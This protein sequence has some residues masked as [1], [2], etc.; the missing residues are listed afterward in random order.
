MKGHSIRML[1][2]A[3]VLATVVL[4]ACGSGAATPKE[5]SVEASDFKFDPVTINLKA[6]EPVQATITNT[7]TL[8]HTFTIPDLDVNVSLAA[9][10]TAT[11]D[12]TPTE[13]GTFELLCTVLGHKDAGM[14]GTVVVAP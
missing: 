6:G 11:I 14:V 8:A 3:A 12:F 2:T 9:G 4:A 5:L 13:S 7:G 1:L 10:Q